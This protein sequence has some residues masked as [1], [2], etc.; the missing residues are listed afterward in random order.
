M[1]SA[2]YSFLETLQLRTPLKRK[3]VLRAF[4]YACLEARNLPA[5][6]ASRTVQR[7]FSPSGY[8]GLLPCSSAILTAAVA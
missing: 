7:S 6:L 5:A 2:L 1:S 4:P 3:N 8:R